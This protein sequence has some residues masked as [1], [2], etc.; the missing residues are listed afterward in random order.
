MDR[1]TALALLAAGTAGASALPRAA[2]AA[3]A[4]PPPA[5]DPAD[6]RKLAMAFRIL[7]TCLARETE[8]QTKVTTEDYWWNHFQ[9][10]RRE[11]VSNLTTTGPGKY[12][13]LFNLYNRSYPASRM[14]YGV[15]I[16]QQ[17]GTELESEIKAL[18]H[19]IAIGAIRDPPSSPIGVD[20]VMKEDVRVFG[21]QVANYRRRKLIAW[22][23]I[24]TG[25]FATI[26][27]LAVVA[28]TKLTQA[29]GQVAADISD[30]NV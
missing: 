3:T 7:D 1:R 9:S 22:I 11:N 2:N 21:K 20:Q 26:A 4:S 8:F 16:T 19:G 18:A 17:H 10:F 14:F 5:F 13:D 12:A 24:F 25:I 15:P 28:R 23:A 29:N 6:P 27:I 30:E